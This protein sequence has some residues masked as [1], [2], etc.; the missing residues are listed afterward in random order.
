MDQ[1]NKTTEKNTGPLLNICM[2]Y[3]STQEISSAVIDTAIETQ[4]QKLG[5][6]DNIE[7]LV[8]NNLYVGPNPKLDL[9]I[10]TSG[11]HRLSNF[12]LWQASKYSIFKPV[13]TYWP[14]ISFFTLFFAVLDYQ[15]AKYS[16]QS[17]SIN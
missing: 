14:D 17:K 2:P 6:L 5:H 9:L 10:R 15:L 1:V 13:P 12:L 3:L 8:E 4:N 16:L 7:L 11:E